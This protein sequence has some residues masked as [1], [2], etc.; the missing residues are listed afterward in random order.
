MGQPKATRRVWAM[1]GEHQ[2]SLHNRSI[3][4]ISRT[5]G[6]VMLC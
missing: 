2:L 4:P 1:E 3:D 5:L 6:F